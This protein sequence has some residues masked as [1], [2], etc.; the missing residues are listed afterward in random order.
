MKGI[1][2]RITEE[3]QDIVSALNEVAHGQR[4][5]RIK[6]LIRLGLAVEGINALELLVEKGIVKPLE[7]AATMEPL[8]QE[9]LDEQKSAEFVKNI[10]DSFPMPG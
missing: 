6:K 8:R 10:L 4:S 9:V 5:D 2:I 1:S 7:V 3:D